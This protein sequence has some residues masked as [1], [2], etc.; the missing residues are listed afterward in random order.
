MGNF[1]DTPIKD[2]NP[3]PGMNKRF[4]WGACSMQGWRSGMEDTHIA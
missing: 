4:A 3:D 1:L 2:K